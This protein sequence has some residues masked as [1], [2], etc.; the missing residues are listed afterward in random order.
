MENKFTVSKSYM[1]KYFSGCAYR[2]YLYRRWSLKQ[3]YMSPALKYGIAVHE[4]IKGLIEKKADPDT[5][6]AVRERAQRAFNWLEKTGHEVLAT[7]AR[8]LAPISELSQVFGIIDVIARNPKGEVVLIDWKTSRNLWSVT[9]TEEGELV[10]V[11]TRGWQGPIY[12]TIPY[13]SDIISIE[14]WPTR[15]LYV[16]LPETGG[17]EAY[18]Y[19]KNPEDVKALANAIEL[20]RVADIMNAY[21]K[22]IGT[23]TCNNCDFKYVCWKTLGWEKYYDRKENKSSRV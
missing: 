19:N 8:H 15:M 21:P 10:Y 22:N 9:T 12:L 20:L 7:E 6:E 5:P 16:V 11:G 17:V 18:E 3:Q 13:E 14:E 23:Y 1:E 4:T 2:A